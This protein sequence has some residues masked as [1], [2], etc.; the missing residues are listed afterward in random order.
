MEVHSQQIFLLVSNWDMVYD[1]IRQIKTQNLMKQNN[2][3]IELIET[4]K[5]FHLVD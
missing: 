2:I 3:K 1:Q 4:D 5:M